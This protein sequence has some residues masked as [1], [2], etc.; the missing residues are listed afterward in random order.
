MALKT[1]LQKNGTYSQQETFLEHGGQVIW[2]TVPLS[3]T[4]HLHH[5]AIKTIL[6]IIADQHNT[7]RSNGETVKNVTHT[8]KNKRNPQ[9]K[10]E[11]K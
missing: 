5:E 3:P 11:K 4:R 9:K 10:N 8:K 6:G 1:Q 2:K 7:Q